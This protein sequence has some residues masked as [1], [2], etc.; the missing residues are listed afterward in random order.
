MLVNFRPKF[1][2]TKGQK[3]RPAFYTLNNIRQMFSK[4]I[5]PIPHLDRSGVYQLSCEDCASVHIGQ[6]GRSLK[7]RIAEHFRNSE[8]SPFSPHLKSKNHISNP[9]A[10]VHLGEKGKRLTALEA[11]EIIIAEN[12]SHV[13]ILNEDIRSSY[14]T[15][16][17]YTIT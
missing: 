13:R 2:K 10:L 5:G 9:I 12:N 8:K 14:L 16:N 6:T 15:E 1:P 11:L 4:V 7:I 17:Y 3:L